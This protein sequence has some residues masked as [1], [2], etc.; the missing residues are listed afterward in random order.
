MPKGTVKYFNQ[1]KRF[2]LIKPDDGS[3]EII[4]HQKDTIELVSVDE[5]CEYEIINTAKGL[6]AVGVKKLVTDF[7]SER[8]EN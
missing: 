2:G 7:D 3:S 5:K 6:N 4:F 8:F 1:Q